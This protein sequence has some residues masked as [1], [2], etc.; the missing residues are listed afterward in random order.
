MAKRNPSMKTIAYVHGLNSS[1]RSFAYLMQNLPEHNIIKVEYNS[2]QS[3]P[4]SLLQVHKQ[5]PKCPL[6]LVGH[7]LGGLI[8][9]L[10]VSNESVISFFL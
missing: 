1:H 6:T 2:H 4:E 5:L 7:S 8:S 3:L 9:A 10:L